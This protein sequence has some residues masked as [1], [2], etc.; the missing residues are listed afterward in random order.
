[1]TLRQKWNSF[2]SIFTFGSDLRIIL[3]STGDVEILSDVTYSGELSVVCLV[4]PIN[5]TNHFIIAERN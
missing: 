3:V 5:R 2:F 4:L 1:M